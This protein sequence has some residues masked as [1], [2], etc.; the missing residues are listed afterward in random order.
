MVK[1]Y[2]VKGI[3][4]RLPIQILNPGVRARWYVLGGGVDIASEVRTA[5]QQEHGG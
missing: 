1:E 2:E 3:L 4:H 5:K